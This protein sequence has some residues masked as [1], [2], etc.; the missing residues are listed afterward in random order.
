M[1]DAIVNMFLGPEV[2]EALATKAFVTPTNP[3]TRD[4][5]GYPDPASCSR[6]TG[7]SSPKRA[8]DGWTIGT[9]CERPCRDH[10]SIEA[11]WR[12]DGARPRRPPVSAARLLP[13]WGLGLRQDDTLA[14]DR[15]T[16]D[17]G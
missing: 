8:A 6:P 10:E 13:C 9:N 5:P 17:P 12:H 16:G 4:P 2:Q 1:S 3:E 14:T 15:G 7:G 11:I